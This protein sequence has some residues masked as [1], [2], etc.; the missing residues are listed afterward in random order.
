MSDEEEIIDMEEDTPLPP[1]FDPIYQRLFDFP[2]ESL[3]P[4]AATMVYALLQSYDPQLPAERRAQYSQLQLSHLPDGGGL[5]VAGTTQ[6]KVITHTRGRIIGHNLREKH[7][8]DVTN[9]DRIKQNEA[10]SYPLPRKPSTQDRIDY[11]NFKARTLSARPATPL[12]NPEVRLPQQLG[13]PRS[14]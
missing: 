6:R 13:H 9:E 14:S 10:R 12:P 2:Y 7:F 1:E 4:Q 3:S 5:G 11:I 8:M